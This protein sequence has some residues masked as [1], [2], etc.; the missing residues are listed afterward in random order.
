MSTHTVPHDLDSAK[1]NTS[2]LVLAVHPDN[3]RTGQILGTFHDALRPLPHE[4]IL[5]AYK[6]NMH[7][8]TNYSSH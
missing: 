4:T 8:G 2:E 3:A 6:H 1:I 5:K 7:A